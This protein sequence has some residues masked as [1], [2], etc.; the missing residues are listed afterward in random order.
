MS[1]FSTQWHLD[2]GAIDHISNYLL[3]FAS[4]DTV[5]DIDIHKIIPD[6]RKI[7]VTHT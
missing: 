5:T 4:F 7:K 3:D 2:S 1:K 6:D